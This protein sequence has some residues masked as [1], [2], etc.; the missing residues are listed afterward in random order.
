MKNTIVLQTDDKDFKHS[1]SEFLFKH[2]KDNDV[3]VDIYE[4]NKVGSIK[5]ME[6]VKAK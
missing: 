2:C 3:H 4:M 6:I 5:V 1:I